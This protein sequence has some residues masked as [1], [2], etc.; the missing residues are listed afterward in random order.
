MI[1]LLQRLFTRIFCRPRTLAELRDAQPDWQGKLAVTSITS[2]TA[3][4]KRGEL[5]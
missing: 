4:A 1:R 3:N 5:G 2:A